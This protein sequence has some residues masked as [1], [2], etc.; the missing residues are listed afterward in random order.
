[1][2]H[3]KLVLRSFAPLEESEMFVAVSRHSFG[4]ILGTFRFL[5]IR[6]A[7][8]FSALLGS[9]SDSSKFISSF[10]IMKSKV[11]VLGFG[12]NTSVGV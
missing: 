8:G 7:D 2:P 1:M 9:M 11:I 6:I 12:K 5:V 3:V 10:A 4:S